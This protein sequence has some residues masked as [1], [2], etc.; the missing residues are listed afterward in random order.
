MAYDLR[1]F[2]V[3]T[4]L[5]Q[6]FSSG[7]CTS[8]GPA[9]WHAAARTPAGTI[10]SHGQHKK[11]V[12]HWALHS[13]RSALQGQHHNA[14]LA[15]LGSLE[16]GSQHKRS[17]KVSEAVYYTKLDVQ[18]RNPTDLEDLPDFSREVDCVPRTAC[19]PSCKIQ[20]H[21]SSRSMV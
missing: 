3:R 12:F 4:Y 7:S 2:G 1:C 5:P 8:R 11:V 21:L 15:L 9:T 6:M 18:Q 17:A 14:V 10:S 20:M 19:R 16:W 13:T